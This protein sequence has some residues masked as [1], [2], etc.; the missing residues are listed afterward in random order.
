VAGVQ[1][2]N[3]S[4][5]LLTIQEC[6]GAYIISRARPSSH[7]SILPSTG[8]IYSNDTVTV[9]LGL[10]DIAGGNT[11]NLVAT[12]QATNGMANSP[13]PVTYGVLI[14]NGPTVSEPFTFTAIGS[15]GQNITAT[16]AL[17]DGSTNLGTVAFGFTMG[18]S[19]VSLPIRPPFTCR[20][21]HSRA[22]HRRPIRFLPA[23]AIPR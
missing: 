9:L 3:P 20:R 22:H 6:N 7:G 18:G 23:M 1:L 10:R 2:L 11:T 17:Q 12:L 13:S 15:N 5:A 19:T 14:E 4:T 21:T 8:V 16:L